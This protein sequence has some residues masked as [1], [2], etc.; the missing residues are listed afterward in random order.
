MR[1]ALLFLVLAV[2]L[3]SQG[4][5]YDSEEVLY[6]NSFCDTVNVTYS[7]TIEPIMQARCATPACH[8]ASGDGTGDFSTRA[9]VVASI[10]NGAFLPSIRRSPGAIPMPLLPSDPLRACDIDK[11]EIW[12]AEGMPDN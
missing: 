4:C 8:V 3:F 5:Y 1:H 11:I 9:G 2:L 12:I 7:S 6:P 10:E